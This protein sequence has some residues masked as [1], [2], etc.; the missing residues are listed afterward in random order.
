M[1]PEGPHADSAARG[2]SQLKPE[3]LG[4]DGEPGRF[5]KVAGR[6]FVSIAITSGGLLLA[7]SLFAWIV[8]GS[9]TARAVGPL[10]AAPLVVIGVLAALMI[11]TK[12]QDGDAGP[13]IIFGIIAIATW[14][15]GVLG[16]TLDCVMNALQ[17]VQDR[18]RPN[19]V[20]AL[21][22]ALS[23]ALLGALAALR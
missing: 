12:D 21:F 7:V 22:D 15:V 6:R 5:R 11:L 4:D 19:L 3:P 9:P 14:L 1:R 13:V 10:R 23:L 8:G 2:C 18:K 17:W 20:R 16:L